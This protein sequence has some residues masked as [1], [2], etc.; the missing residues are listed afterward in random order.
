MRYLQDDWSQELGGA[1][2][3][4]AVRPKTDQPNTDDYI[5]VLPD[6]GSLVMFRSDMPHEVL[7]TFGQ[8]FALSMWC[9]AD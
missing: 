1:F 9:H 8:R 7:P 6:G 4:H 5:D 2:R 3:A